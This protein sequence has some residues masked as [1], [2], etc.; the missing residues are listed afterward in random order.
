ME[1]RL[2]AACLKDRIR[3]KEFFHDFDRLRKGYVAE[4]AVS[5]AL[6]VAVP[7]LPGDPPVQIHR[8]GN[9]AVAAEVL[10][11]CWPCRLHGLLQAHRVRLRAWC[12][13]ASSDRELQVPRYLPGPRERTADLNSARAQVQHR[14]EQDNAEALVP[15]LRQSPQLAHHKRP[16]LPCPQKAEPVPGPTLSR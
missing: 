6:T 9:P 14:D 8:A 13:R 12:Q 10:A 1:A 7:H 4:S 15:R 3:I 2:Q 5:K 16:V 11:R